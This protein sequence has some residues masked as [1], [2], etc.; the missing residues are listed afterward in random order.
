M[1][2]R[3]KQIKLLIG[4]VFFS[5][6]TLTLN[7][8]AAAEKPTDYQIKAAFVYNFLKF[9]DWPAGLHDGSMTL[10][11]L[12]KDPFDNAV[13]VIEGKLI[14]E[15]QLLVKRIRSIQDVEEGDILFIAASEKRDIKALIETVNGLS[16]LTIGDTKKYSRNGV[17]I[18]FY[19]ERKKVRFEINI[20]AAKRA[21]LR[22]SSKL[23]SLAKIVRD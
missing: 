5:I 20:D 23:L 4:V 22:I 8:E 16:I 12:G 6:A 15:K 14:G 2:L 3:I 17:I 10:C 9:I 13:K 7:A 19:I 21:G 11:I 18:N 1:I